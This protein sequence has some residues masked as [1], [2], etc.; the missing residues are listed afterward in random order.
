MSLR[1]HEHL[2]AKLVAG[3]CQRS[4]N[5]PDG[6][7]KGS[8][9]G[10]LSIAVEEELGP[11]YAV[12]VN[13]HGSRIRNPLRLP[14]SLPVEQAES[15]DGLASGV[16][17]QGK[18]DLPLQGETGKY[19]DRIITNAH[20]LSAGCIDFLQVGLQLNQL[21]L[22]EWSPTCRTV[23]YHGDRSLLEELV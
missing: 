18:S 11:D 13:Y 16:G 17:E 23:E 3:S 7:D 21:L 2:H 10:A 4:L 8:R 14:F 19:F 9:G 22:A 5:V 12:P 6:L 1:F 20:D 15:L